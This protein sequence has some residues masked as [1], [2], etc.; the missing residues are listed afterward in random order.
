MSAQSTPSP[1]P[2]RIA[3]RI[4]RNAYVAGETLAIHCIQWGRTETG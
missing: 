2:S 3:P 4:P 1:A